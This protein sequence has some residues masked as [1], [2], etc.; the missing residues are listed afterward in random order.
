M[1]CIL[2]GTF[3]LFE[4][5]GDHSGPILAG[6]H[7]PIRRVRP[8]T[9]FDEIKELAAVPRT[10]GA[11][12]RQALI[13]RHPGVQPSAIPTPTQIS[14]LLSREGMRGSRPPDLI[15]D[16]VRTIEGHQLENASSPDYPITD[17]FYFGFPV[18]DEGTPNVGVGT[19]D[20]P[21]IVCFATKAS[22]KNYSTTYQNM[23]SLPSSN[24]KR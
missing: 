4:E 8:K 20:S 3:S 9:Y 16:L 2:K 17:L 1:K 21:F 22:L 12:I 14:N 6:V 19:D 5:D 13:Q 18:S 15:D 10:G 7:L 24:R 23:P 11:S